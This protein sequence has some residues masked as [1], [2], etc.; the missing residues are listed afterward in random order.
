[1]T[2]VPDEAWIKESQR[3]R[4]ERLERMTEGKSIRYRRRM[5]RVARTEW[6]RDIPRVRVLP[7]DDKW[8]EIMVHPQG[9][10]GFPKQGSAEWPLDQFT[11]NRLRDGDI[12]LEEGRQ[13]QV[14]QE[15]RAQ[16]SRQAGGARGEQRAQQ[17]RRPPQAPPTPPRP[18]EP[19]PA[20]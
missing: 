4:Q 16:Q 17:P 5:E 7:K 9:N 3:L 8:R 13:S 1:M 19:G 15:Q 14:R 11:Y 2:I 10:L 18:D 6:A 12:T 20:E